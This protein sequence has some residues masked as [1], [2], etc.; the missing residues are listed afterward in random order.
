MKKKHIS[1]FNSF[2]L[3]MAPKQLAMSVSDVLNS[4]FDLP[5]GIFFHESSGS[6]DLQ[7]N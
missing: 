7:L 3:S 4:D 5:V 6:D 2:E 1:H